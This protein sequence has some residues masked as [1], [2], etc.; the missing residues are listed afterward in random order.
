MVN[1]TLSV[2]EEL[3]DIMRR[4]P[5][6]KWSEVARQAMWEYARKL[7][8]L[9]EITR[10]SSFSERDAFEIGEKVKKSVA[11]RYV[12]E[13]RGRSLEVGSRHEH[14]SQGPDQGF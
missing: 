11:R 8:V 2:P 4:Y 5:E 10:N 14:S 1:V 3:H 13:S 7:K 12:S 9:D 6:I